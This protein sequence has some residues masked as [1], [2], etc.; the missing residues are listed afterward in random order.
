MKALEEIW[1]P[2]GLRVLAG[3]LELRAIHD[4]DIPL[5]VDLAARGIHDPAEMPFAT[6]WSTAPVDQLER[7][8]ATFYWTSRAQMDPA[9]WTLNLVACW[10]GQIVGSQGFAT[11]NFLVTRSGETG[12]WL[13]REFQG[14]GIGTVMR[15]TI[16]AFVLDHLDADEVT[17]AAFLDNPSSLA[18]SRKVGYTANGQSREKRRDGEV[19]ISQRLVLKPENLV[20]SGYDLDVTGVGPFRRFVGLDA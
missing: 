8:M 20:R 12:S 7:S 1:P 4:T 10:N 3:P 5:L 9:R 18:V 16:C 17:S 6:P 14:R 19:A 13:G 15:Q 11:E 2:L